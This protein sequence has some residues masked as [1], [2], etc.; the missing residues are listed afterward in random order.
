[1]KVKVCGM[2]FNTGEVAALKPDYLGFIFWEKSPRYFTGS[3]PALP[4]GIRKVGVFVNAPVTGILQKISDHNLDMVQLHG[5][6]TPEYC[7]L[8]RSALQT[9][10]YVAG[11]GRGAREVIKVFRV[12]DR[13]DLGLLPAFEAVC[14]YFLFDTKGK[15]P[16]GNGYAF[17]WEALAGYPSRKP[18]VLSGGI[19]PETL[20]MLWDFFEEPASRYCHAIDLN[21]R[22][23]VAPGHKKIDV[24]QKFIHGL[25]VIRPSK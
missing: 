6:E 5:D 16:G 20:P 17:D 21:S 3:I 25:S 12:K 10:A 24:L 2:K 19:G 7:A 1:M 8:L 11:D 13:E 14:D 22:F 23:E 18:Y 4:E 15:L 9:S